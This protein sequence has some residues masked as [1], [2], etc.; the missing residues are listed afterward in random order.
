MTIVASTGATTGSSVATTD[1]SV[2]ATT[3]SV[4]ASSEATTDLSAA[5]LDSLE[6]PEAEDDEL[7]EL[8]VAESTLKDY[9]DEEKLRS[10][11][12]SHS[13]EPGLRTCGTGGYTYAPVWAGFRSG[14][15]LL[16]A[17]KTQ[18]V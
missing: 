18:L 8:L 9:C 12:G 7:E 14:S 6:V 13:A 1:L 16:E 15:V 3:G 2:A 11:I 17:S 5:E 10:L 4:S